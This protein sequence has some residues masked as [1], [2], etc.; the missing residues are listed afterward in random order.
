MCYMF[1][2]R[3]ALFFVWEIKLLVGKVS[4]CERAT[5][6]LMDEAGLGTS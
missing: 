1:L 2:A 4:G 3:F 5:G 6:S